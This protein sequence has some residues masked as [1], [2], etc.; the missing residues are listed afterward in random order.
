MWKPN[1]QVYSLHLPCNVVEDAQRVSL[2]P[3]TPF[4]NGLRKDY[5]KAFRKV[6]GETTP[7][8]SLPSLLFL[9]V[10]VLFLRQGFSV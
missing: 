4:K 2:V 8:P 6:C 7:P 10:F 3:L 5:R 9:L 1:S